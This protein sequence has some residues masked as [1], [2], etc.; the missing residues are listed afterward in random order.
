[1]AYILS[2]IKQGQ[3]QNRNMSKRQK[4]KGNIFKLTTIKITIKV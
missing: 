3:R 4:A 2:M 1:M